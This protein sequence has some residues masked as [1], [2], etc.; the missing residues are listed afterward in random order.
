MSYPKPLNTPYPLIDADPHVKR[1]I[2][3]MRPTDYAIW[4]GATFAAPAALNFWERIDPSK[5]AGYSLRNAGRL[6]TVVGFVGGFLL[7][8]QSSARE[9]DHQQG[10]GNGRFGASTRRARAGRDRGRGR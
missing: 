2:S 3:Y 10:D 8:Y 1:V 7:A 9:F 4:G 5:S 6:A